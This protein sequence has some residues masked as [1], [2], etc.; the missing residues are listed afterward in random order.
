VKR[1][2][3]QYFVVI[4]I[5]ITKVYSAFHPSRVGKWIPAI[6]GKATDERVG[7]QVKLWNPREH[8]PYMSA[9]AVVI[10]YEEALY[11]VYAPLPFV[12]VLT[13]FVT[14]KASNVVIA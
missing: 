1:H 10:H 3:N 5:I 11:Q 8:V 2:Y 9:S 13:K 4:T 14:N 12:R 7:V 6:A